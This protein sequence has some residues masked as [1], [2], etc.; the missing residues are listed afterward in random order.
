MANPMFAGGFTRGLRR[1]RSDGTSISSEY[2]EPYGY[3]IPKG[4]CGAK[5][6]P[7]GVNTE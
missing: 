3:V 4:K 2:V 5:I 7:R 1:I 6:W